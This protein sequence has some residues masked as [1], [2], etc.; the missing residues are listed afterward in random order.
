MLRIL[1]FS[2]EPEPLCV[3]VPAPLPPSQ[4]T[5]ILR[6]KGCEFLWHSITSREHLISYDFPN[7]KLDFFEFLIAT[8]Q[9]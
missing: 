9:H 3:D 5:I 2:H 6:L 8:D 4:G 7:N 1:I